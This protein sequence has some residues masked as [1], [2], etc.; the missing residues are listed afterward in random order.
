MIKKNSHPPQKQLFPLNKI[1]IILSIFCAN[2]SEKKITQPHPTSSNNKAKTTQF[3]LTS[4]AEKQSL[5]KRQSAF[6][7]NKN[8]WES[9]FWHEQTHQALKELG[10]ALQLNQTPEKWIHKSHHLKSTSNTFRPSNPKIIHQYQGVNISRSNH[11]TTSL[12]GKHLIDA[13]SNTLRNTSQAWSHFKQYGIKKLKKQNNIQTQV[14]AKFGGNRNKHKFITEMHWIV[15]WEI[16]NN[17]PRI[18]QIKLQKWQ[19]TTAPISKKWFVDRSTDTI[20]HSPSYQKQ[21]T[22]G[23][24]HWVKLITGV[25]GRGYQGIAI[26][27]LNGDGFDDVFCPQPEGLANCL[28]LSQ[29]D[30]SL[31]DEAYKLKLAWTDET[32][33]ALIVDFDNDGH[34]DLVIGTANN[35]VFLKNQGAA[36]SF[37][38]KQQFKQEDCSSLAAADFD[39]DGLLD[40]FVGNYLGAEKSLSIV[41]PDQVYDAVDGSPNHL[42]KNLGNFS[43]IDVTKETGI[44][45]ESSRLALAASW[46]DFDDDGDPDLYVAN[47]FGKNCLYVNHNGKFIEL[48]KSLGVDDPSTGMS[49]SWGDPNND[50]KMD[51]IVGNMFSAAGNRITNQPKFTNNLQA[52]L[53]SEKIRYLARG[54]SLLIN[55]PNRFK[56]TSASSG[57]I[58]SQWTWSML[59]ADINNNGREDILALNGYITGNKDDDL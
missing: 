21:L 11:P 6:K 5:V 54:N 51:L 9:E 44:A 18:T 12:C 38:I 4:Q 7:T 29:K 52:E 2:C 49:V 24:N 17:V 15:N 16:H 56:E 59:F 43:F 13:L 58:N 10:I 50:G 28:F 14:F 37:Q 45:K 42:Y 47:D 39:G 34:Q 48:S 1:L 36:S 53:N 30:G 22:K 55:K 46:E 26:G 57:V 20:G 40:L 23:A 32:V 25:S 27:D 31:S 41:K 19:E 35:V 3:F 33:S 8:N